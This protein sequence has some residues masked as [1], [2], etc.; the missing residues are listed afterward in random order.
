MVFGEVRRSHEVTREGLLPT[1][2]RRTVTVRTGGFFGTNGSRLRL[3]DSN[4]SY[5]RSVCEYVGFLILSQPLTVADV[6]IFALRYYALQI[7][8]ADFVKQIDSAFFDVFPANHI[9]L[10]AILNQSAEPLFS[11]YQGKLS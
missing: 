3:K 11:L 7:P 8:L 1:I 6:P 9:R 10:S 2:F 4:S 5:R